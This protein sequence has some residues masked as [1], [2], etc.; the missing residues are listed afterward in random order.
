MVHEEYSRG[1][2]G[3]G[4]KPDVGF[5]SRESDQLLEYLKATQRAQF[6]LICVK[7]SC[8]LLYLN[9]CRGLTKALEA[10]DRTHSIG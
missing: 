9:V 5:K 4:G 2:A 10:I 8:A 3:E 6:R 1:G 7:V